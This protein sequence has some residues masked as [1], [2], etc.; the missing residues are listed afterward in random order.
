MKAELVPA[1]TET[2]LYH[3]QTKHHFHRYAR[4]AGFLDWAN[5]P[6][7]FR[8]YEGVTPV[9]LPLLQNDPAREHLALYERNRNAFQDFT[10]ETIGAFLELSLGLSAWK[11]IPGSSWALRMNPSSGNLHPTEAYLILP[12]LPAVTAGVFH[13]NPFL[14][15]LEPRA[16]VPEPLWQHIKEHLHTDGFLVALT[17]IFWREAWKYGERAFRYCQ[18]D[19]GHALAALSFSAN[20]LGWKV[21][22]LNAVSDEEIAR[23]WASIK[24]G[25]RSLSRSIPS[26]YVSSTAAERSKFHAICH[27]RLYRR[28]QGWSSGERPIN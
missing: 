22:W 6:N 25:G 1:V 20:L 23:G 26:C 7:P 18:H 27:R 24:P 9:R 4:S 11:S 8:F 17:S 19:V 2:L 12:A 14:H 3:E 13:Y 16:E 15:A 10:R 5:Q 21:T 28:F